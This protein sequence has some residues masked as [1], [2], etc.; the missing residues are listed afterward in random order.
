M[1]HSENISAVFPRISAVFEGQGPCM[2][3]V[4]DGEWMGKKSRF[5]GLLAGKID[6]ENNPSFPFDR[7]TP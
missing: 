7:A 2:T 6:P 1:E 5:F 3:E 4:S